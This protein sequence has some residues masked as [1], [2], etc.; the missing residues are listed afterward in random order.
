M[1]F[2]SDRA[3][4]NCSSVAAASVYSPWIRFGTSSH[5]L[6]RD[7]GI[8]EDNSCNTQAMIKDHSSQTGLIANLHTLASIDCRSDQGAI[9]R[10]CGSGVKAYPNRISLLIADNAGHAAAFL[11]P[12]FRCTLESWSALR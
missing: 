10:L 8:R 3:V 5:K 2:A 7:K 12:V 4:L 6:P 11:N 9:L 1:L